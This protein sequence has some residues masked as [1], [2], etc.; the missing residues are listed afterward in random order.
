MS[1]A[2]D[3]LCPP[4]EQ[5]AD[6]LYAHTYSYAIHNGQLTTKASRR[7]LIYSLRVRF[8]LHPILNKG[9]NLNVSLKWYL[10]LPVINS[11]NALGLSPL[12]VGM[13]AGISHQ[14]LATA[15]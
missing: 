6:V 5:D 3:R 10:W 14:G 7:L 2:P 12:D 8:A 15:P 9:V 11:Y 4:T 1:H 13:V